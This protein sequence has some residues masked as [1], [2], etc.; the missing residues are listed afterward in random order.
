[1]RGRKPSAPRAKVERLVGL[2][3]AKPPAEEPQLPPLSGLLQA[4]L[5]VP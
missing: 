5:T 4:P 2:S 1:M 3:L